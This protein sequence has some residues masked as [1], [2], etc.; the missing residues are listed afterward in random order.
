MSSEVRRIERIPAPVHIPR[1]QVH[2]DFSPDRPP[3]AEVA[4]GDR[5]VFATVDAS[6]G[7][8][9][10]G[11]ANEREFDATRVNGVT[12]PVRIQGAQ[13]G[14]LLKVQIESIRV[15]DTGH[16]WVRPGLGFRTDVTGLK[17]HPVHVQH[18]GP[19]RGGPQHADLDRGSGSA[20]ALFLGRF[21]F[22]LH[23]HVGT[24]GVAPACGSIES[25]WP[26]SHGG[27]LDCTQARPGSVVWLPVL[28]PGALLS[29]GDVHAAMGEGEVGGTGVEVEAEVT[30]RVGL[31]SGAR[32]SGPVVQTGDGWFLVGDGDSLEEAAAAA[33]NRGIQLLSGLFSLPRE[34]A[35][36]LLSMACDLRFSQVAL[37]RAGVS[38]RVPRSIVKVTPQRWPS[39]V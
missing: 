5:V 31:A 19:Q 30:V 23:P 35:Y 32:L 28:A 17:V 36:M 16:V 33:V 25:R 10:P 34:E 21:R 39:G 7:Q 26:G 2:Y 9:R 22:P 14:Q 24:I 13:V 8:I 11:R 18:S 6:S 15:A 29:L 38:L 12:G 27:N 4:P 20:E 3:A 37:R 1:T